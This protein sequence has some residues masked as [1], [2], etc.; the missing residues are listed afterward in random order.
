MKAIAFPFLVSR[1]G[2]DEVLKKGQFIAGRFRGKIPRTR[3]VAPC[4]GGLSWSLSVHRRGKKCQE[5]IAF[6]FFGLVWVI[7]GASDISKQQSW[8]Y[9]L[10]L[11]HGD[12][13]ERNPVHNK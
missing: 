9:P 10:L 13:G 5:G 6:P 8:S 4:I 12:A 3:R 2:H 1:V 7:M 11:P